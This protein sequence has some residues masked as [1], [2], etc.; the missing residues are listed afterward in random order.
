MNKKQSDSQMTPVFLISL[1][2]SGSTLLQKMLAVS[3][4]VS[5]I[6]EPWICLPLAT[7]LEPT[8]IA[9][10]YWHTTCHLALDDLVKQLPGGRKEYLQRVSMFVNGLYQSI[11]GGSGAELFLDKTP[12]YYLIVPFLAEAFPNARF[13]FLFRNPLEV[14][15]SVLKTWHG[16][17]MTPRLRGSYVDIVRGPRLMAEGARLLGDRA[18]CLDYGELVSAPDAVLQRSCDYLGV[19]FSD[20]MLSKYKSVEFDGRMGDPTGVKS[21]GG[22]STDSLAIWKVGLSNVF[23]KWYVR[24]YVRF[25]GDDTLSAFGLTEQGLLEEIDSIS[26]TWSGAVSDA[27]GYSMF[28]IMRW[29]NYRTTGMPKLRRLRARPYLP[30]G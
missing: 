12:R 9:A 4:E 26:T 11:D 15:S 13:I 29:L 8:A 23:R 7:M 21:Y 17:R 1:P 19:S 10:E 14:L 28:T 2:R 5:T 6:A 25:L 16:N 20:E 18:L 24:R 3:P 30:Y 27:A 22:I